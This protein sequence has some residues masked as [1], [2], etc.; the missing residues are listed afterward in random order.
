[1]KKIIYLFPICLLISGCLDVK[2]DKQS[3]EPGL[4]NGSSQIYGERSYG[5]YTVESFDKAGMSTYE[6]R[7]KTDPS[8]LDLASAEEIKNYLIDEENFITNISSFNSLAKNRNGLRIGDAKVDILG[9]LK[10]ETSQNV[11]A[12]EVFAYP[13]SI[14]HD[15][16]ETSEF[17]VD[18]DVRV[19]V[20]SLGYI[21]LDSTATEETVSLQ[22]CAFKL[23]E[24]TNNILIEVGPNRAVIQKII[25]Y[26]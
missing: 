16:L 24:P 18:Q 26:Y 9:S 20:N 12:I 14:Y 1:M 2:F 10:F 17:V 23:S 11:K 6:V 8:T 3:H 4:F 5:S 15:T 25:F 13:F 22:N 19:Q 7:C 21:T